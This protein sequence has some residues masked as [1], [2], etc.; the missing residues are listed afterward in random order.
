MKRIFLGLAALDLAALAAAGAVGFLSQA[1]D[2]LLNLADPIYPWHFYLGL[3]AAL[4][5]ILLHCIVLTYFLGTGRMVKEIC[6]GYD[7]PD[8]HWPRITRDLKR[9]NTPGAL[10]AMGVTTACAAS[11]MA[12]QTNQ[13]PGWVHLALA[14]ATL[15]VNAAVFVREYHNICANGA[16]LDGV[17]AD[18][19]RVRAE[20]GLPSN[21]EALRQEEV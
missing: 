3:F 10:L 11:G 4:G 5:T 18:V 7:L 19:D 16:V 13:W 21:A 12:Q 1:R 17:M 20:R 8:Q 15:A 9:R 14:L 2:G 6:L